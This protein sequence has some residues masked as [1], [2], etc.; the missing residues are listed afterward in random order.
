MVSQAKFQSN[1]VQFPKEYCV[2]RICPV[3]LLVTAAV[4][5]GGNRALVEF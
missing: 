5:E 1:G 4:D 3:A 2:P